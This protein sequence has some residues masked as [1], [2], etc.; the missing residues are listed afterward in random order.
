M[1]AGFCQAVGQW[2]GTAEVYDGQGRFLANGVDQR[3]VQREGEEG[4]AGRVR[5]DLS[6]T[7]PFKFAGHYYIDDRGT[8]RVYE[9][10]ANF[11]FAEAMGDDAVDAHNYWPSVGLSQRFFLMVLPSGNKQLSLALLSRGERLVYAVV[12][13]NDKVVACGNDAPPIPSFVDG[14]AHDLVADP[15]AGRGSILLHRPGR[16]K[17]TLRAVDAD[18]QAKGEAGFEEI[19]RADGEQG[20]KVRSSGGVFVPE[21]AEFGLKTDGWSAWTPEG[22]MVGSYSLSGGRAL[23]GQFHRTDQQL[24][25]WRREVVSHDGGLKAVVHVWHRG[26][27]RIGAQWGVLEFEAE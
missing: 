9:G 13:E 3:H 10:P 14:S 21:P 23:S 22:R 6:F 4:D 11:G 8:E 26:G 19:V 15:G 24:R 27:R 16:W 17:G 18:Y 1:S 12:G 20:L 7:G 5:I 2:R 25:V